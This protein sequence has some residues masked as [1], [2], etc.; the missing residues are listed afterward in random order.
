MMNVSHL[1]HL[2]HI[3]HIC[4]ISVTSV[5]QLSH[6]YHIKQDCSEQ[7]HHFI[8]HHRPFTFNFSECFVTLTSMRWSIDLDKD[9]CVGRNLDL[10][11]LVDHFHFSFLFSLLGWRLGL[12]M[13]VGNQ[14]SKAGTWYQ[15]KP[16]LQ[17][18]MINIKTYSNLSSDPGANLSKCDDGGGR[19]SHLYRSCSGSF[20]STPQK[21]LQVE[22]VSSCLFA[23]LVLRT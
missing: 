15:G 12:G 5:S 3:C 19:S 22:H 1:S 8:T 11:M 18:L 9:E 7:S 16:H 2:C 17:F 6:L 4:V 23:D 21:S 20:P 14:C 10:V 13:V